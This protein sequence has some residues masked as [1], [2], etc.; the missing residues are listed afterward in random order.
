MDMKIEVYMDNDKEPLLIFYNPI[1]ALQNIERMIKK[2]GKERLRVERKP[3]TVE[4]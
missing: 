3:I 1:T 4:V 2:F